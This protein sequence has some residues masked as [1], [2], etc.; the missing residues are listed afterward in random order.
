MMPNHDHVIWQ[1]TVDKGAWNVWVE[2]GP[3]GSGVLFVERAA[4]EL[5]I[6]EEQVTLAY[7]AVFGPDVADV[8]E[9]QDKTIRAIDAHQDTDDG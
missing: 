8:G 7:G 6:L 4:D 5:I 9:W 1:N 3:G 2:A